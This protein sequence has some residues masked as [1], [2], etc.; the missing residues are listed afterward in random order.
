MPEYWF[1]IRYD[2]E[3]D[4]AGWITPESSEMPL[5][6]SPVQIQRLISEDMI[7]S[8]DANVNERA[9]HLKPVH[10]EFTPGILPVHKEFLLTPLTCAFVSFGTS[11]QMQ[12]VSPNGYQVLVN[13][14]A[15]HDPD[16]GVRCT[17]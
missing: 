9:H 15:V 11:T 13:R 7:L 14:H 3:D 1:L 12:T 16:S 4:D 5:D 10:K 6:A 2:G 8:P 17:L